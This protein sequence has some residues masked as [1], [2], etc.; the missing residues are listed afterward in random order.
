M[1]KGSRDTKGDMTNKQRDVTKG[2]VKWGRDGRNVK[3][4][5]R[6]LGKCDVM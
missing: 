3:G 1:T 2:K 5:T 6:R 4:V